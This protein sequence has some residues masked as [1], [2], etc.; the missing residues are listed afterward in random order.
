MGDA[1]TNFSHTSTNGRRRKTRI[2][3]LETDHGIITEQTD[4]SKHI[5]EF[6][7]GMFDSPGRN[8]VHLEVGFWPMEEQLRTA[9]KV[10]LNLPFSETEVAKAITGMK[11]DSALAPMISLSFSLR[12]FGCM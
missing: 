10:L 9:K 8:N 12:S 1:N 2:C 5:V 6:Y 7:K 3:S 11:S 4:I